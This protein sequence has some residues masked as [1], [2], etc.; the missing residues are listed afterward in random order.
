MNRPKQPESSGVSPKIT[1]ALIAS[2]LGGILAPAGKRSVGM[3]IGLS[4]GYLLGPLV[5]QARER[6]MEKQSAFDMNSITSQ[7]GDFAK[8]YSQRY[9]ENPTHSL[10]GTGIGSLL[11]PLLFKDNPIL[12]TILTSALGNAAGTYG[13]KHLMGL[14]DQYNK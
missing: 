3:G 13:G 7:V 1:G 5:R 2:L 4:V 9:K 10:V 12:G 14:W 11:G 6:L 8:D